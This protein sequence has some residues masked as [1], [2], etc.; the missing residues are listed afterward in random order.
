MTAVSLFPEQYGISR[1]PVYDGRDDEFVKCVYRVPLPTT[2][3][4]SMVRKCRAG[5]RSK[6]GAVILI[7]GFG[8]NRYTWHTPQLSFANYLAAQDY[9]VFNLEL[10]GFGRSRR[11]GSR[12]PDHPDVHFTV[13]LPVAIDAVRGISG[14]DRVFLIGHSLGGACCYAATALNPELV[15]GV[16]T[17]AGLYEVAGLLSVLSR[18][19]FR[20][21]G[22][23]LYGRPTRRIVP[24]Q[25]LGRVFHALQGAMN[26]RA[27]RP[28]PLQSWYP[29]A[30]D[31]TVLRHLHREAYERASL[32]SV[33]ALLYWARK[34]QIVG[35][36][37]Y[38][39]LA[40]FDRQT[41]P[42]LVLSG[43]RDLLVPPRAAK[44]AFDRS[45]SPDKTYRR[46]GRG[47]G[48]HHWGHVDLI[49]GRDAPRYVW[50]EVR[51]WL[52]AR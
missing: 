40:E 16:V 46:F 51:A 43:S 8:Q 17:F 4:L 34:G 24:V 37:G 10:R 2:G 38:D 48:G 42:L 11:F 13:D 22:G 9:D 52:D 44:P 29:K 30:M 14:E 6:R 25:L 35:R 41:V 27:Y 18:L 15:R 21:A 50:P 3:G 26:S 5:G 31:S 19:A 47:D 12:L 36:D 39:F 23:G 28:I 32:G 49:L 7:H 1:Q 20:V 33:F 45:Q